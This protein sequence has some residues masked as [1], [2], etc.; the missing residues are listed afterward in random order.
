MGFAIWQAT[1]KLMKFMGWNFTESDS[2][3]YWHVW[4]PPC[5]LAFFFLYLCFQEHTICFYFSRSV[6]SDLLK[7][8][9]SSSNINFDL[10][11][12]LHISGQ[13][14]E[15]GLKVFHTDLVC[16]KCLHRPL[17]SSCI[18]LPTLKWNSNSFYLD[19]IQDQLSRCWYSQLS[20]K[21]AIYK[22][23]DRNM[24]LMVWCQ[25]QLKGYFITE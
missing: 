21:A 4:F 22:T 23:R 17:L 12:V 20:F 24:S 19:L 11:N 10:P 8:Q 6:R 16:H 2:Y 3:L 7:N 15:C 25:G 9:Y 13:K 5:P 18:G 1:T 14:E